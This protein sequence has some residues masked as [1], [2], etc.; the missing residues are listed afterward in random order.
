[1]I[2]VDIISVSYTHLNH[3]NYRGE[4]N[5]HAYVTDNRG[6][7]KLYA[8]TASVPTPVP[9]ITSASVTE[10]SALGYQVNAN[11]DCPLGVSKAEMKTWTDKLGLGAAVTCL[12]Y[13]SRCV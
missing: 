5:C 10:V 4:Y 13:T 1:M 6:T 12:L 2:F 3:G 8:L 9:K 7:K 11:F